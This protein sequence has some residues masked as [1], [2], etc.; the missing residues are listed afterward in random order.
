MLRSVFQYLSRS[1]W[2]RSSL[3]GW[4]LARRA[5]RRFV[6]GETLEEATQ[7]VQALNRINLAATLAHLGEEVTMETEANRAR[8]DCLALLNAM[9]ELQLGAYVSLKLTQIGLA[10]DFELCMENMLEIARAAAVND[11]F[12]RIDMEDSSTIDQTLSI[13]YGLRRQ[14]LRDVGLVFQSYLFRS[15]HD[16]RSAVEAGIP[17]R[18]VKGAYQEPHSVA[19]RKKSEVDANF[20]RMAEIALE[21][22]RDHGSGSASKNGRKPPQTAIA[23]HDEARIAHAEGYA[24]EIGLPKSALEFQLL[25]GIRAELQRALRAKGYPVRVY[26]PYG[27]QWYPYL[28]RRLAERPANLWFFLSNFFRR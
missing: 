7:A 25:Y 26:V 17:V 5:S 4:G 18:I 1:D 22:A 20:D 21:A 12:I 23:S 3:S 27:G 24:Q 15:E 28:M 19:F 11:T 6:A 13:H 10:I 14:G 2:A 9:D 8:Q 16:M